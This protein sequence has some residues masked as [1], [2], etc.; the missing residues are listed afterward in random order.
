M[1]ARQLEVF[2]AVMRAGT[3]TEA[4]RMLN[5]SQPALSQVLRHTEDDLGFA[6]FEREKG[7]LRPT[8]E[9]QELFPE[10]ER[11]F[12]E[13]EGL[14][15][16]TA[17]LRLGRAGLVRVASSTPPAMSLLPQA[18]AT[19]RARHP[20]IAVRSGVAPLAALLVMLREGDASLVLGLS[21][22]FPPDI[23][24]EILGYTGFCCL[25]PKDHPLSRKDQVTMEQLE[26]EQLISYRSATR[27]WEKLDRAWRRAGL[28][29]APELEIDSSISAVGFVQAGLGVAVVDALLPWDQFD[30]LVNRPLAHGPTLPLSL[31]TLKG[32]TLSRAEELM[33]AQIRASCTIA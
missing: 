5:I 7:R 29:F 14:R 19:F 26:G 8:P 32:K 23:D 11:I 2:T 16:K 33:R 20:D 22:R 27:P 6:L 17:D 30:G 25:M 13:L 9:A 3:V 12:G 4:A 15:R 1:R 21:D 24:L 28:Q 18:L 10:A 31:L